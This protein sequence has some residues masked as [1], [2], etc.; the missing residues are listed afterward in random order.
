MCIRY[1]C[2][3][4]EE[5]GHQTG[6]AC[7]CNHRDPPTDDLPTYAAW[8]QLQSRRLV[9]L[10]YWALV[11]VRIFNNVAKVIAQATLPPSTIIFLV[12]GLKYFPTVCGDSTIF[13]CY[14]VPLFL[15]RG[16]LATIFRY[17]SKPL[18]DK[19]PLSLI[20]LPSRF[21]SLVQISN[22]IQTLVPKVCFNMRTSFL[23]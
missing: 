8:T 14:G 15:C 1:S 20:K 10:P 18:V 19:C 21:I 9:L 11:A 12:S 7:T 23:L 3:G 22:S 4:E 2:R 5:V 13:C 16:L 17:T 6:P